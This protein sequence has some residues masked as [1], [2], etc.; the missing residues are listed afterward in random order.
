MK[1]QTVNVWGLVQVVSCQVNKKKRKKQL[2]KT[3]KVLSL[4]YI[5]RTWVLLQVFFSLFWLFSTF[6]DILKTKILRL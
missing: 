4:F 6:Q 1:V 3:Q 2:P 5:E